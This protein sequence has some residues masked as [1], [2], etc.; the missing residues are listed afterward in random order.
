MEKLWKFWNNEEFETYKDFENNLPKNILEEYGKALEND[1]NNLL[2]YEIIDNV[3]SITDGLYGK[4][5]VKTT[6][7]CIVPEKSYNIRFFEVSF[8]LS[9]VYPCEFHNLLSDNK[10]TCKDKDELKENIEKEIKHEKI[11]SAT[12]MLLYHFYDKEEI[13]KLREHEKQ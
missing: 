4:N 8:N 6:F 7:Y 1:F 10:H 2:T 13:K 12:G 11:T 9:K 3:T 5:D